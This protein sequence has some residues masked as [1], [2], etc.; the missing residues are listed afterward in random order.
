M[1]VLPRRNR[2]HRTPGYSDFGTRR[3]KCGT[4]SGRVDW[5]DGP[6]VIE[7]LAEFELPESPIDRPLRL[8]LQDVF[9]F[10]D[11]RILAGRIES[12]TLRTGD[13]LLFSPSNRT[14]RIATIESWN[15][16]QT[17]VMARAGQSVGITLDEQVFTERGEVASH[18]TDPPIE[19]DVFHLRLFWLAD[20]PLEI[21]K[22]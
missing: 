12:G 17:P 7:T 16:N 2:Y 22:T 9:K 11:R 15:T 18:V 13:K 8:P 19:T 10:D 1:Y 3:G 5:Y 6:S 20:A 4:A 14:A 21:G